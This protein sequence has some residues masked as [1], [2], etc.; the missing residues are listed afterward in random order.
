MEVKYF[1]KINYLLEKYL[2]HLH[3]RNYLVNHHMNITH[4]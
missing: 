4:P 1:A 3:N 2:F